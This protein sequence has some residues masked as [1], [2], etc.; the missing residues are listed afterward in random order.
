M[1]EGVTGGRL[2]DDE[3]TMSMEDAAARVGVDEQTVRRWFDAAA[4]AG[5]PVGE[6]EH[7]DRGQPVAGSHRRP[8][9]RC[10]EAWRTRRKGLGVPYP[11][12]PAA[13]AG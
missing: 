12:S 9:R 1:G 11:V 7:D 2:E 10:V 3:E 4:L 8:Y 6:R 13:P 5:Q